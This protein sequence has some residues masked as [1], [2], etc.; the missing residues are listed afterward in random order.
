MCDVS[1]LHNKKIPLNA[2]SST[3]INYIAGTKVSNENELY[4]EEV[5]YGYVLSK[6][7]HIIVCSDLVEWRE[8]ILKIFAALFGYLLIVTLKK[9]QLSQFS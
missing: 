9:Y 3:Y 1:K 7:I 4:N 2:Y 8:D 6:D 5:L